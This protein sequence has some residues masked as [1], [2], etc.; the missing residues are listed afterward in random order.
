MRRASTSKKSITISDVARE[1]GVTSATVSFTLSGKRVISPDTRE[2]VMGAIERLGYSPN[3]HAVRLANGRCADLI[4]L[5]TLTIDGGC[6]T[7]KLLLV[8]RAL[9]EDGFRAPIHGYD[10]HAA[11]NGAE[12]VALM[13]DIRMQRPRA[14]ICASA[15]VC[16][17]AMQELHKFQE[18][19]GLVACI[20][21]GSPAPVDCDQVILDEEDNTYQSARYLLSLG[22]RRIGFYKVGPE[23]HTGLRYT[24]Y[25]RALA[26]YEVEYNPLW[27]FYGGAIANQEESGVGIAKQWAALTRENR[28]TAMCIVNDYTAQGFV[29]G[30]EDLGFRVP[31]DVSIVGHDDQPPARFGRIPLTTVSHPVE[32]MVEVFLSMVRERIN[33]YEGPP[34]HSIVRGN[35]VLRNSTACFSSE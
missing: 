16:P 22:H 7:Q 30:V 10:Y 1:A 26:E 27:H 29:V 28:P 35:L 24:G 34:R 17:E 4:P 19:G 13:R 33:G 32:E 18:E 20:C 14:V 15:G 2:A 31:E 6:C 3:P 5:F 8:Q 21:Y 25:R 11:H 12:Q 23:R 9:H